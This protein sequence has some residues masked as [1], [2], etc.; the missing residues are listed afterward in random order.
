ML[1]AK[2]TD[3]YSYYKFDQHHYTTNTPSRQ[4]HHR[5]QFINSKYTSPFLLSF[6]YCI[7]DTNLQRI[8]RNYDLKRQMYIFCPITRTLNVDEPRSLIVP[9][10]YIQSVEIPV[11]EYTHSIKS[12]HRLYKLIQNTPHEFSASSEDHKT[13]HALELL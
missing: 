8:I 9:H 10:E 6:T 1:R 7:K 2:R 3:T 12:N 11:L 4:P 5:F 13:I